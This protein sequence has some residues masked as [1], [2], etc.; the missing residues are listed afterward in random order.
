MKKLLLLGRA[1]PTSCG[2]PAA[3]ELFLSVVNHL[4]NETASAASTAGRQAAESRLQHERHCQSSLSCQKNSISSK[5]NGQTR[6]SLVP[7]DSNQVCPWCWLSY[8]WETTCGWQPQQC[9][10]Q[11]AVERQCSSS[12]HNRQTRQSLMLAASHTTCPWCLWSYLCKTN[13][14][15]QLQQD[16]HCQASSIANSMKHQ[17]QQ[18]APLPIAAKVPLSLSGELGNETA[19]TLGR[20]ALELQPQWKCH[21]QSAVQCQ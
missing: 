7:A 3:T 16:C 10:C 11:F 18:Q 9:Y 5:H 13:C 6:Q 2:I 21:C 4:S 20:Q 19:S 14:G 12:K 1:V 15:S 17:H 8:S